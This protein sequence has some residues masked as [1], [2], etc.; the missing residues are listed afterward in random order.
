MEYAT[1]RR[2][3][4]AWPR[5][6]SWCG[7]PELCVWLLRINCSVLRGTP[8]L[9]PP[10]NGRGSLRC[11]F[12]SSV[13]PPPSAEAVRC[14]SWP[15]C[16]LPTGT[17]ISSRCA[18]AARD[19]PC[20]YP[21]G[22]NASDRPARSSMLPVHLLNA[23]QFPLGVRLGVLAKYPLALG[24]L[25]PLQL[26]LLRLQPAHLFHAFVGL[27]DDMKLVEHQLRIAEVLPRPFDVGT[28]HVNGHL[29]HS[30]GM[31]IV[32]LKLLGE[33][34]PHAGVFALGPVEH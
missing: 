20:K 21:G 3:N 30:L 26:V 12:L 34:L 13:P 22:L 23:F 17:T 15:L 33:T 29:R 4:R 11:A 16:L 25:P 19:C 18:P 10:S 1:Y 5:D 2:R 8:L 27:L 31:P 9:A 7:S 14:L 28:A 24:Q 32:S 6:F